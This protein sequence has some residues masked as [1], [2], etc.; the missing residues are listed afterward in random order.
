MAEASVTVKEK[1]LKT[2]HQSV[3]YNPTKIE[4]CSGYRCY[5]WAFV[6]PIV[7]RTVLFVGDLLC[8]KSEKKNISF[9]QYV[10]F[11][12]YC[13]IFQQQQPQLME[14][15]MSWREGTRAV[16]TSNGEKRWCS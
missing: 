15:E 7:Q 8:A 14:D 11:T 10:L 16:V 3:A 1:F 6:G 5:S 9:T 4:S 13:S 12:Q 2:L